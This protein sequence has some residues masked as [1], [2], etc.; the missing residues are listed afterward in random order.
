MK[1]KWKPLKF[2]P[3]QKNIILGGQTSPTGIFPSGKNHKK[4]P[5]DGG[6][7]SH[8]G[9][10][11]GRASARLRRLGFHCLTAPWRGWAVEV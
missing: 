2:R 1:Q 10:V 3:G 7:V 8:P 5:P 4:S 9:M 6:Q 11:K